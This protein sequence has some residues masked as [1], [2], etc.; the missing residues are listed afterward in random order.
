MDHKSAPELLASSLL[1]TDF[2]EHVE[3]KQQLEDL[4]LSFSISLT[5]LSPSL[6]WEK[7]LQK[8]QA[9]IFSISC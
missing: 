8:L 9:L 2:Y 3:V 6:N 5:F 7:T 4:P 1:G